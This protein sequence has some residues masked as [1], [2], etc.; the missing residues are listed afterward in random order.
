[1]LDT[2]ILADGTAEHHALSGIF[3]CPPQGVL[4]DA[5]GLDGVGHARLVDIYLRR[6]GFAET[7]I[8]RLIEGWSSDPLTAVVG[9]TMEP[10]EG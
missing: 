7:K 10:D 1:M 5:D 6:A 4:A 2:L 9:R 8:H 3:R